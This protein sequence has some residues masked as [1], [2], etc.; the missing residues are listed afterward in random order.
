LKALREARRAKSNFTQLLSATLCGATAAGA[1]CGQGC[2]TFHRQAC[3][4]DTAAGGREKRASRPLLEA[5]K[6]GRESVFPQ[7][8]GTSAP[9]QF[10]RFCSG[11]LGG[12][13][14]AAAGGGGGVDMS[15][16]PTPDAAEATVLLSL[17]LMTAIAYSFWGFRRLIHYYIVPALYVLQ[18]RLR[19]PDH[20][21]G[22]TLMAAAEPGMMLPATS[23]E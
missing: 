4:K 5:R 23:W 1:G 16:A 9:P 14:A 12:G 10:V 3:N 7:L 15:G 2:C 19:V 8:D 18:R 20:V 17:L 6:R 22:A 11:M 13:G 21:A